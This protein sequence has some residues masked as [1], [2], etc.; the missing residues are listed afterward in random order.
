MGRDKLTP[1]TAQTAAQFST[2]Q[3]RSPP[4]A[5]PGRWRL[6]VA[7]ESNSRQRAASISSAPTFSQTKA[8]DA[9]TAPTPESS[10]PRS[11]DSRDPKHHRPHHSPPL[12]SAPPQEVTHLRPPPANGTVKI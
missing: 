3:H 7:A 6:G 4:I 8:R 9:P 11:L 2:P 10:S 12:T 1:A 5:R